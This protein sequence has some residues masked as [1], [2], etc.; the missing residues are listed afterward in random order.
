MMTNVRYDDVGFWTEIKLQIIKEYSAAYSN[1]MKKR[2]E[3][4][5]VSGT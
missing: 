3:I 5:M 2:P 1:I 4:R